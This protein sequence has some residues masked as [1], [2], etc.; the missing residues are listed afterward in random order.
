MHTF[1]RQLLYMAL[2]HCDRIL[3]EVDIITY[4]LLQ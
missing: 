2:D 4:E 1:K 3:S